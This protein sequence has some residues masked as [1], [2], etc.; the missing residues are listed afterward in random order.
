MNMKKGI[1]IVMTS[2]LAGSIALPALSVS[3]QADTTASTVSTVAST[4]STSTAKA[5]VDKLTAEQEKRLVS[6]AGFDN[7]KQFTGFYANLR[8]AVA[9]GNKEAVAKRISYP[10]VINSNNKKRSILKESQFITEYNTIMTA[11]VKKALA[12]QRL[13][14]LF[15][16]DMGVMIGDGELW[17]APINNKPGIYAINQ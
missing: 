3:A 2:V 4:E 6:V 17:I 12:N 5:K 16:R 14:E 11:K 7:V 13:D 15:I 9:N 1:T 10:L 8:R